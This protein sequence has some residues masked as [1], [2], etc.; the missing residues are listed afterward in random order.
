MHRQR[1]L[2]NGLVVL[3]L[4]L[5][6]GL[7]R[8]ALA[9][10]IVHVVQPGENLFRIGLRYG[11]D[12]RAIMTANGLY[13]TNIYAG[14]ALVIPGTTAEGAPAPDPLPPAP[15]PPPPAPTPAP[16]AG[17]Y[18]VQPG[19][20]LWQIAQR[21]HTTVSALIRANGL[22]N[23]NLIYAGQV[24]VLGGDGAPAPAPDPG[25]VLAVTGRGQAL[26][27][28]CES[29]SA[30]DWANYF[31]V[32]L[33]ELEFHHQLPSSDDP[34]SGFV[35]SVYGAWGQIPPAPYGVHPGPVAAL[36]TAS[37]VPARA[38]T[39]LSWDALR[40]EIDAGRPVITWVIGAVGGGSAV[41]YTAASNGHTTLVAPFEHTVM[42]IGYGAD[43]VTLLDG[44]QTYTR[45]LAQFLAS[46][47]VLGNMAIIRP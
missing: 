40:A 30:V 4:A 11:V 43:S 37:G 16:A 45:T 25:K 42:V 28:D 47:G 13:S 38:V 27:L 34:D 1:W 33:D 22:A 23:G 18:T 46:W 12:W 9:A 21:F 8:A 31:G 3:G 24:L 10:E 39:G 7:P 32:V 19:D 14:Q 2:R 35:G 5:A 17:T 36:L 6:L 15:T 29:R 26:P 41:A 20:S 44:G